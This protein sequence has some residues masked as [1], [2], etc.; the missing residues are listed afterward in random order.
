MNWHKS[1]K[2]LT[3]SPIKFDILFKKLLQSPR[4]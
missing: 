3:C 1:R 4:A 2:P